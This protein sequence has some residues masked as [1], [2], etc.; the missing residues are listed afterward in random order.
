MHNKVIIVDGNSLLF[1]AYYATAYPGAN[2]MRTK[3]G[4]ATN[5][6]FAFSNMILK[7]VDKL[8]DED[9]IFV[10]FDTGKKTF[11]HQELETYKANRKPAPE[12]LIVQFPIARELLK[13]LGIYTFEEEGYEGDDLAGSVAIKAAKAGYQTIIYT[14]DR[15]FL[16]LV[17]DKI[18]VDLL[19][20]GMS[21]IRIMHVDDVI[22]TYGFV[23]AHI[24]DFKGLRGDSSDNLPGIPS[25][26][27][28]TAQKLIQTYGT[29]EDIIKA[30]EAGEIKGKVGEM[31]SLHK[32]EGKL[33][34]KLAI[35]KTDLDL[36]FSLE[37]LTY[38]GYL[39]EKASD[40]A[41]KY[42][43]K[44]FLTK[45]PKKWQHSQSEKLNY[46]EI[47]DTSNITLSNH[48]S[49]VLASDY[50]NY[51]KDDVLV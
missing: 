43:L 25:I 32:E 7:I 6:I 5:A 27:E 17:D 23:P 51:H 38:D 15:D 2:I 11:R 36:P 16:Q 1:R 8:K 3:E 13:S 42:E 35:I 28:K 20:K 10:A 44:T 48:I 30:A 4:L 40:F 12:D 18:E 22:E 33:C 49:F 45:L 39:F 37:D 29:L 31:I 34:K 47:D 9:K 41:N 46:E 14:S 26:G 21:D 19:I 50:T 24:I